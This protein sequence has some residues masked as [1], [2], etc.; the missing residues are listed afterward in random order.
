[1]KKSK[2]LHSQTKLFIIH[3]TVLFN[4]QSES[5]SNLYQRKLHTLRYPMMYTL[6][7][8]ESEE[9]AKKY[10]AEHLQNLHRWTWGHNG[11]QWL[12]F[13]NVAKTSFVRGL[14][15]PQTA[16][17]ATWDSSKPIRQVNRKASYITTN[18]LKQLA[19]DDEQGL[20]S[21]DC[22][23]Q[24]SVTNFKHCGSYAIRLIGCCICCLYPFSGLLK[25]YHLCLL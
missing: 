3:P 4:L 25:W 1:M 10:Q 7:M 8:F 23:L 11:G 15:A 9:A 16:H 12:A 5:L 20:R 14:A 13:Q 2:G 17:T 21:V 22:C 6:P 24:T 18:V 19:I